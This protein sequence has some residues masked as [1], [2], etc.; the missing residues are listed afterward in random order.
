MSRDRSLRVSALRGLYRS[1]GFKYVKSQR[2]QGCTI[3]GR[4]EILLVS[5]SAEPLLSTP[6]P[7]RH[8]PLRSWTM[9][10]SH[11]VTHLLSGVLTGL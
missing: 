3:A 2:E 11:T 9:P 6:D 1:S 5:W 7:P 10:D 4:I 8:T